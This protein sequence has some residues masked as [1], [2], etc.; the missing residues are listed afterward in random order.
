[1]TKQNLQMISVCH[2]TPSQYHQPEAIF[3]ASPVVFTSFFVG[4]AAVVPEPKYSHRQNT[5]SNFD[6]YRLIQ[7]KESTSLDR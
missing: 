1:M 4:M 5:T 2:P 7:K 6:H 3:L